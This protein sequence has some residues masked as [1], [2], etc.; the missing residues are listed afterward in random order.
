MR[1]LNHRKQVPFRH[2]MV[3]ADGVYTALPAP[4]D[5]R[6]VALDPE[7]PE[8]GREGARGKEL[9][10]KVV[11]FQRFCI[12]L[13]SHSDAGEGWV[14]KGDDVKGHSVPESRHYHRKDLL[15]VIFMEIKPRSDSKESTDSGAKS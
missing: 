11:K 1:K 5:Q 15:H 8:P 9:Y 2:V 7:V 14:E 6:A 3:H 12:I 4:V 10:R 13:Y